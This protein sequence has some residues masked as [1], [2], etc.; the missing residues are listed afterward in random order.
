M[1][2]SND[3]TT[4]FSQAE[5]AKIFLEMRYFQ[6]ASFGEKKSKSHQIILGENL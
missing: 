6:K 4:G 1:V 5:V 3:K 2:N